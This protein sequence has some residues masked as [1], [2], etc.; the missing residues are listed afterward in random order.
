MGTLYGAAL[1]NGALVTARR[2]D[3]LWIAP[4]YLQ[5]A[6][7]HLQQYLLLGKL[8][9]KWDD[10]ISIPSPFASTVAAIQ[11]RCVRLG[12]SIPGYATA[13]ASGSAWARGQSYDFGETPSPRN[14]YLQPRQ[15]LNPYDLQYSHGIRQNLGRELVYDR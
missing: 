8:D 10:Q 2:T 13:E 5:S 4:P 3:A 7:G 6:D 11:K 15:R 1:G 9:H 14:L 12:I